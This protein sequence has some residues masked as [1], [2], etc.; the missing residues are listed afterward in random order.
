[1]AG[2]YDYINCGGYCPG[3]YSEERTN[4]LWPNASDYFP[5]L[6]PNTGHAL[7]L[8]TNASAGYEVML[9]YLNS[10]GL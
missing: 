8:S 2:E 5:Y 4:G 6:Q 3:T 9:G 7:T 1:M 10:H